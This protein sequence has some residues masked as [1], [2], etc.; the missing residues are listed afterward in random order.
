MSGLASSNAGSPSIDRWNYH[1]S[2][3]GVASN[4]CGVCYFVKRVV[5]FPPFVSPKRI[6]AFT[7]FRFDEAL[8]AVHLIPVSP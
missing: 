6:G 1:Y 3:R 4:S 5:E 7:H 2:A 8:F